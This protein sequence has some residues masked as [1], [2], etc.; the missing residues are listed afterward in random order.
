MGIFDKIKRALGFEK[1]DTR[2]ENP[3]NEKTLQEL[4]YLIDNPERPDDKWQI[5]NAYLKKLFESDPSEGGF[6]ADFMTVSE[7]YIDTVAGDYLLEDGAHLKTGK[8]TGT[9]VQNHLL[10]YVKNYI[11]AGNT[12]MLYGEHIY[13]IGN[14]L[15]DGSITTKLIEDKNSYIYNNGLYKFSDEA[16]YKLRAAI[17]ISQLNNLIKF[18]L[19]KKDKDGKITSKYIDVSDIEDLT[20]EE[21]KDFIDYSQTCD[22][23]DFP[24]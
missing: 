12:N 13:A 18:G 6:G 2:Y 24:E 15:D 3:Y 8:F 1:K 23:D 11:L 5:K 16:A 22:P 10:E 4:T 19:Y 7:F 9:T 20:P 14:A 21:T 17:F